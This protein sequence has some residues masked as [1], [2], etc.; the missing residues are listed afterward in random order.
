MIAKIRG[1]AEKEESLTAEEVLAIMLENYQ[2]AAKEQMPTCQDTGVAVVLV[3]L[4]QDVHE[5]SPLANMS[6]VI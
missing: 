1:F 4:G 3:E 5:A 2:L 6:E